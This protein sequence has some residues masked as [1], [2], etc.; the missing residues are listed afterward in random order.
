MIPIRPVIACCLTVL[1]SLSCVEAPLAPVLPTSDVQLSVPLLNRI[2]Y[3]YDFALKDSSFRENPDGTYLFQLTNSFTPVGIDTISTTL[4]G[5]THKRNVGTFVIDPPAPLTAGFTFQDLTGTLPPGVPVPIPAGNLTIP[6]ADFGPLANFDFIAINSG[7]VSLHVSN[8]LQF[9]VEFVD[10]FI[11]RNNLA[12]PPPD[13][14][15]VVRF[16]LAG[17]VLAPGKDTTVNTSLAGVLIRSLVQFLPSTMSTPGTGGASVTVSDTDGIQVEFLFSGISADSAR[18]VIPSQSF[19]SFQDSAFSIMD[20][21]MISSASFRS[22]SFDLILRNFVDVDVDASVRITELIRKSTGLSYAQNVRING[23]STATLTFDAR[24][25]VLQTPGM[26]LGTSLTV[27]V[28]ATVLSSAG[29]RTLR[30][31]DYLEVDLY[32]TEPFRVEQMT[33]RIQPTSISISTG[34]SGEEFGDAITKFKGSIA[35]DSIDVN[36]DLTMP[37]GFPLDYDLRLVAM[38]RKGVPVQSDSLDIPPPTGAAQ[39]RILP[40][41]GQ[42][43]SIPLGTTS[44]INSFLS[45]F[46]PS[47]PDTFIIRGSGTINPV[48]IYPTPAGLRTVYDTTRIYSSVKVFFPV[49][50]SIQGGEVTDTVDLGNQE[51]FPK[52]FTRSARGGTMYFEVTNS[53]PFSL[54]FRAAFIGATATGRDTLLHV[55]GSGP[56]AIAPPAIGSNGVVTNPVVTS[57]AVTLT[58]AEMGKVNMADVLWYSLQIETADGSK[59]VKLQSSNA[60][61]V[62]ASANLVYRVNRQ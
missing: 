34:A 17:A 14:N 59:P 22:G 4:Q 35:F 28:D 36:L 29:F 7:T 61:H 50:L 58:G 24:Q 33:G 30:S 45:K 1:L 62:K 23:A 8:N 53:L 20:S 13:M 2:K 26:G 41:A 10:P 46:F 42:T 15:E 57:F 6:G 19:T 12:T 9:P 40:G 52:D 48:D 21:T 5:S 11:V 37:T 51:K 3:V 56:Q 39:K 16:D 25:F 60:V 32:P 47:L 43:V 27:T 38:N 18:A 49:S 31:T 55:P 54:S 44:T